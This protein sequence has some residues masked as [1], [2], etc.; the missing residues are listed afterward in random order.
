M[1]SDLVVRAMLPRNAK[2]DIRRPGK[3]SGR[4]P[5]V[6]IVIPC[7]NY[8]RYLPECVKSVL[9]Q[10]DVRVDV[11][12]IDDASPDGSAEIVRR[13]AEEDTRTRAI[14]HETNQG[15]IATYNEGLAQ[16]SGDYTLLLSADDRLTAGCLARATSLMEEY[17]SVGLAYG[18]VVDF[19]DT[20]LPPARTVATNWI[21]WQGHDWIAHRCKSGHNVLRSP[22]AVMRT[23][24]LREVGDYRADL[25]HTGDLEMWMRAASVS[26]VGYVGGADQA[27]YR[28]HKSNMHTTFDLLGDVSE[29]LR[30]FD[31]F[32]AERSGLL[33]NPD[34]MRDA[35]HC[36]LAREALGHAISAYARGFAD[37][38]SVDKYAEFALT[39]WPDAR[40]LREWRTLCRL[41]SM[42]DRR[43]GRSPSLV[44]REAVRNLRYSLRWWRGRLAGVY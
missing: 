32:F 38:E 15:H 13:L 19:T 31:A 18:F 27:Y 43:L 29:R 20:R 23:S 30:S 4:Q 26:D 39:A 16:V 7:Y 40:N 2:A 3:V 9:D 37:Q 36:A 21:I 5:S 10:E 14:C 24:V 25:P 12:V 8:G 11:L 35:A 34:L 33:K 42:P 6:S 1:L 22:E 28:V 17:P 41:R 44:T